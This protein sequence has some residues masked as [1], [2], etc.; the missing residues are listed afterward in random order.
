MK[1][2]NRVE[3]LPPMRWCFI[4]LELTEEDYCPTCA[5]TS[6]TPPGGW[7]ILTIHVP[8]WKSLAWVRRFGVS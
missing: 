6:P 1:R 5:E 7:K 4:C 8:F 2:K 3:L